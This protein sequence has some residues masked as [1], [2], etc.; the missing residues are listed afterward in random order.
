[1]H[2]AWADTTPGYSVIYYG[3]RDSFF[4]STRPVP[5]GR[6]VAPTIASAANGALFIAWQDRRSDTGNFDIFCSIHDDT[7]QPPE[8]V[9]DSAGDNSLFPKLTA[10]EQGEVHLIWQ[11]ERDGL[12]H[13]FQSDRRP[14]GWSQPSDVSQIV[15]DCRLA[16]IATNPS[17]YIHAAWSDGQTIS[18]GVR[19]TL[20]DAPWRDSETVSDECYEIDGLAMAVSKARISHIVWSAVDHS[21]TRQIFYAQREQFP[22]HTLYLPIVAG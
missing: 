12:Y 1:M 17:G 4:W 6:G 14:N 3:T 11:E 16:Q 10:T 2:A 9:S 22:K 19:P 13:V 15:A 20:L 8:S 7:W 21:D 18:L 5:S